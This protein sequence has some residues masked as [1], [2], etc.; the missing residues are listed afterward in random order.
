MVDIE[1]TDAPG[2]AEVID[3]DDYV[4]RLCTCS[5]ESVT[6]PSLPP[7]VVLASHRV[8]LASSHVVLALPIVS[9]CKRRIEAEVE[10]VAPLDAAENA[11]R[12]A[13]RCYTIRCYHQLREA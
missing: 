3:P 2:K 9:S 11:A 8:I 10:S 13:W 7:R 5:V 4:F 6:D 12:Q 1:G